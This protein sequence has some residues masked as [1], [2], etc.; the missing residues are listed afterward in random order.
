MRVAYLCNTFG[1][2]DH[3]RC[4]ALSAARID[5]LS[6]DWARDDSEYRWENTDKT[7]GAHLALAVRTGSPGSSL[8][9]W[10]RMM[11]AL[12]R[13]KPQVIVVY[14]YHNPAFFLCA[15]IFS[16]LGVTMLTMNDSRFSDYPRSVT[17]DALKQFLLAPYRGCLAGS[18]AAADYTRFL[19]VGRIAIYRCAIDTARVARASKAAFEATAFEDRTFLVV[20]RFVEKKNL[21]RLLDAYGRYAAGASKARRL[22]LIGYGPMEH[23]LRSYVAA[24]P[25]LA[26]RVDVV[27]FISVSRVPE[28][29]GGSLSLILPSHS[30]QFGIVVTEALASGVPAIVS[31]NCGAAEMIESWSNGHVV[32]VDQPGPLVHAMAEMDGAEDR[33]KTM[34]DNARAS[35]SQ[36]DVARFLEAIQSLLPERLRSAA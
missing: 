20:S 19:G 24:N 33:W 26:S 16:L 28:Y 17:K 18:E 6:I 8:G 25:E 7:W 5:L 3:D 13:F 36:A 23:A 21:F 27:G 12:A 35:A 2:P 10:W 9:A 4:A 29:I 15:A 22:V 31:S 1:Q 11:Q 34:S 30:D 14:G 32:N